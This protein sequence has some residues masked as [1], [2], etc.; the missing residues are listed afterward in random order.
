MHGMAGI[1]WRISPNFAKGCRG[2]RVRS[3]RRHRHPGLGVGDL[4]GR[5]GSSTNESGGGGP[6]PERKAAGCFG[7]EEAAITLWRGE[8]GKDAKVTADGSAPVRAGI[9]WPCWK[10]AGVDIPDLLPSP[11]AFCG[12]AA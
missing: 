10:I 7:R 8:L 5:L 3:D 2:K 11:T 9:R 12:K 6:R 4:A 1:M